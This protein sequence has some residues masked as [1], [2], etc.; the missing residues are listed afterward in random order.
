MNNNVSN[1]VCFIFSHVAWH[2]IICLKRITN[3]SDV[4]SNWT[5]T[6]M[7]HSMVLNKRH[8][9]SLKLNNA[10]DV[11]FKR[12][13]QT[14]RI[15]IKKWITPSVSRSKLQKTIRILSKIKQRHWRDTQKYIKKDKDFVLN[16]TIPSIDNAHVLCAL[17]F[18]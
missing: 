6:S 1:G 12:I 18:G 14:I 15:F 7:W 10:I 3:D 13:K 11:T 4:H 17:W 8:I 5:T 16:W 9:F 2:I